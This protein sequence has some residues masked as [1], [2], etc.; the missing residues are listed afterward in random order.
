MPDYRRVD[1]TEIHVNEQESAPFATER[2]DD[3]YHDDDCPDP[4][5]PQQPDNWEDWDDSAEKADP[6]R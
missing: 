3:R 2:E 4:D 5:Q 6:H 1:G